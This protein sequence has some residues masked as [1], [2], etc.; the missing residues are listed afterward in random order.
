MTLRRFVAFTAIVLAVSSGFMAGAQARPASVNGAHRITSTSPF[1]ADCGLNLAQTGYGDSVT[2][3]ETEPTLGV[4]PRDERNLVTSWMQDL[5]QGYAAAWSDNGGLTWHTSLV[6]GNSPCNGS[7]YEL[8]ADPW[9]S[10]GPDGTAYLAGISLD[11]SESVPRLP[12]R[13]RIQVNRSTDGGRTWSEPSV[14][15]AGT[16]RLHDKPSMT[17]HPR[18]AGSGYVV[19]TEF[20]TPLGP[21]ADGI[22]FSRT[23]DGALTWSQPSRVDF[24]MPS[25][26]TPQGALV[27]VL[28]DDSLLT[29]TTMRAPNGTTLPHRI[30]ATRSFDNGETWSVPAGVAEFPA[31]DGRHSTPW[32]DPETGDRIDAPEWAISAALAPNDTVFVTWRH[33]VPSLGADIRFA[34]SADGGTT[35]STPATI[36]STGAQGFLPVVAVDHEGT[37]GVTYYDDRRDQPGDPSYSADFWFAHSHDDGASWREQHVAG[38]FDLRSTLMRRIPVTGRFVGDYHGLVPIRGGF[39]S[40]FALGQPQAAAGGSDIFSVRLL[41]GPRGQGREPLR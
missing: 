23:T 10:F 27:L 20:L 6:L 26:A 14:I 31:T 15:V 4:N 16:G 36:A 38:P 5:Y 28:D 40:T 33:A 11:V 19:W 2:D 30:F 22:Y 3:A 25:G 32:N 21:P 37:V 41:T 9:L 7:E 29:L 13:S 24:P 8:A 18:R 12:F 39:V 35:W 17:A 1:P 34:K